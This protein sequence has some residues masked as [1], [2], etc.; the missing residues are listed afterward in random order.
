MAACAGAVI[1]G[2]I[3]AALMTDVWSGVA[4]IGFVA[5]VMVPLLFVAS[6]ALRGLLRAWQPSILAARLV[7]PDGSAPRL[8][9]WVGV[10]WIGTFTLA[11]SVFQATWLLAAWT[12]FKPLTIGFAMPIAIVATVL[13][14]VA[15]SRPVARLLA[16]V[17]RAI[18]RRW[19]GATR[20]TLLQPRVIFG[21]AI[22]TASIVAWLAWQYMVLPRFSSLDA[23]PI[24]AIV[25]GVA[26]AV[27]AHLAWPALPK[28]RSVAGSGFAL[29]ALA[30]ITIAALFAITRPSRTLEIWGD[31]EL[32]R[33]AI[34]RAFDLE[35]VHARIPPDELRLPELPGHPH[36]DIVLITVAAMRADHTPVYGGL[37]EMPVLRALGDRGAV[38]HWTFATS[39]A[40]ESGLAAMHTGLAPSRIRP[41]PATSHRRLDPRHI[42][43]AERLRAAGYQTAAFV[44]CSELAGA[45]GLERGFDHL[46]VR[47]TGDALVS[48]TRGWLDPRVN[49]GHRAPLFVWL[50][51]S[52]ARDW[53]ATID[54]S[55]GE[56]ERRPFYDRALADTDVLVGRLLAAFSSRP[57][58]RA[59]VIVMTA[60]RGEGLGDH[61]QPL[62]ARNLYNG[63]VRVPLV[64]VGPG[65][66]VQRLYGVVS[67]T[68][69][70]PTLLELAG[71][72]PPHPPE[73]DGQS[74]V[75]VIRG[76]RPFPTDT[77]TAF[78]VGDSD[79]K[80]SIAVIRG[81][82]K[83]IE[84]GATA[85]LYDLHND[86]DERTNMV[87]FRV[88]LAEQLRRAIVEYKAV[89]TRSPF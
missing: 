19:R 34:E 89:A 63:V 77:G 28:A 75:P 25:A 78:V 82:W 83:L 26:I 20:P 29:A 74:L 79:R 52:E 33:F 41:Q 47:P 23:T 14:S 32:S 61:A 73:P 46:V 54:R 7:E 30:T 67:L 3:D 85:E 18:D 71:F 51:V 53:Q 69:L 70:A 57:P 72:A 5:I 80:G 42:M 39:T 43:V 81:R 13:L 45:T 50:H 62:A 22:V 35:R 86:P 44:C 87:S 88:Q 56:A 31:G 58:D 66:K 17:A 11:W 15:A 55:V 21:G 8:A 40:Q 12:A 9:G 6:V 4:S 84:T 49:Q 59:P 60:D 36:P 76:A 65:I 1:A 48:E 37:A 68:D 64:I 2:G 24:V 27:A 10:V 38:F 16:A